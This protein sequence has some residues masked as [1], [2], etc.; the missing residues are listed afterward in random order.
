MVQAL[1]GSTE[2]GLRITAW[3]G[4]WVGFGVRNRIRES[5]N[6]PCSYLRCLLGPI[7]EG[8]YGHTLSIFFLFENFTV[9]SQSYSAKLS[10]F[11]SPYKQYFMKKSTGNVIEVWCCFQNQWTL[12]MI[13]EICHLVPLMKSKLHRMAVKNLLH[14]VSNKIPIVFPFNFS[15]VA[16]WLCLNI[17][18]DI[19]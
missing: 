5:I 15:I 13:L 17:V 11:F 9:L 6:I 10:F 1:Q 3:A 7:Q 19:L 18:K 12:A 16:C 2:N 14:T 4:I 8:M